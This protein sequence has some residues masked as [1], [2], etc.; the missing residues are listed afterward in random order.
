MT[1]LATENSSERDTEVTMKRFGRVTAVVGMLLLTVTFS[2][3]AQQAE[4]TRN[5]NLEPVLTFV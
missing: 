3:R 1:S 4:V 5:V 2:L